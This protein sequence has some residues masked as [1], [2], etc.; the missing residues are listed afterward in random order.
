MTRKVSAAFVTFLLIS[1]SAATWAQKTPQEP[2]VNDFESLDKDGDGYINR[3]EADDN[4]I[5]YHFEAVDKDRDQVLSREEFTRYIAEEE[6]LLGE[7]LPL[8]ELP[9]AY[10]RERTQQETDA[11]T[12]RAL[13]PKIETEFDDLDNNDDAFISRSEA[14]DDDLYEHFIHMDRNDDSMVSVSE[15]ND[16]LEE[17]GNIVATK[18][19]MERTRL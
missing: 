19:L 4:N 6:P 17:Y 15:Y 16:Y 18:E 2:I 7:E 1:L 11:V 3:S 14:G 9:Q 8:S 12:N 13:L 10:L 5:Y